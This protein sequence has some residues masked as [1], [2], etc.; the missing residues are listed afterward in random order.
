MAVSH[1]DKDFMRRCRKRGLDIFKRNDRK[2][3]ER[4]AVQV[5]PFHCAA[6]R[7]D[8]VDIAEQRQYDASQLARAEYDDWLH[9]SFKSKLFIY[10]GASDPTLNRRSSVVTACSNGGWS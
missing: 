8:S 9:G 6:D 7:L 3:A 10:R 5:S 1:T 2:I 4:G